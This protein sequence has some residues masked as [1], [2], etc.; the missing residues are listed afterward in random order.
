MVNV[1]S[2]EASV[3]FTPGP[4]SLGGVV[5]PEFGLGLG[6]GFMGSGLGFGSELFP[7]PPQEINAT[8]QRPN[9]R[10]RAIFFVI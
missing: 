8:V 5:V 6:V 4:A 2:P 3:I 1:V 9:A 10:I 7:L